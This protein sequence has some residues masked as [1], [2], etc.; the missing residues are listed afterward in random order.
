M[1]ARQPEWS[2]VED[3]TADLLSLVADGPMSGSADHEW[4]YFVEA[5][6]DAAKW[7]PTL[8]LINPNILRRDVRNHVSPR[9]IGS[10]TNRALSRG[11]VEYTGEWEISD[12]TEGRNGGKPC[13]VMRWI[14]G[15]L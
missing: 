9:R 10:F 12:D 7:G 13:R 11:L 8:G 3:E 4:D 1:T 5:L 6:Y 15:E 14:G 2:P